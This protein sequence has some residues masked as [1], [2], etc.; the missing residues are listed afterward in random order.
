MPYP[1]YQGYPN[2]NP[3]YYQQQLQNMQQMNNSQQNIQSSAQIQNGGFVM[4]KDINE[5]MNYP[6]APGNSVTFKNENL[7]Y[8]YTKTLGFSQLDN[9]IFEKFRL[10]KE[11]DEQIEEV[12]DTTENN[13]P[14]VEYVTK[15]EADNLRT[16][17]NVLKE[18]INFLKEYIENSKEVVSA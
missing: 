9:P 11:V 12:V 16:E 17:I 13:V 3:M 5:A 4:V 18:E 14:F 15:E 1:F 6:V 7:P 8:I 10:V 2:Y